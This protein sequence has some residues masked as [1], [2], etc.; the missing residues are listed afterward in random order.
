MPKRKRSRI[1]FIIAIFSAATCAA[2]H[3]SIAETITLKTGVVL[4]G[5]LGKDNTT[6]MVDDGLRHIL[7][8]D[9]K[10]ARVE[11]DSGLGGF[12]SFQLI[13]PQKVHA[14][15]MPEAVL[16]VEATDWD[17]NGRRTFSYI[18]ARGG[19]TTRRLTMT[20]ALT[21]L[22]PSR[23]RY[24]GVDG[25]WKDGQ[26]S[27]TQV[28]RTVVLALLSR[29][30]RQD[31]SQR[32]KVCRFLIEAGWY[33]EA[34]A[35][36]DRLL[37]DF[38]DPDVRDRA[39]R[40][41]D[42]VR[43]LRA[44]SL[45]I[46]V[47]NRLQARRPHAALEI[48]KTFPSEGL[49]PELLDRAKTL[50]R[51]RQ[52]EADEDKRLADALSQT[53]E[54]L[55][56]ALR[57]QTAGALLEM[58]QGLTEAPDA[59]RS[60]LDAFDKADPTRT[61]SERFA[62]ALSGWIV[63]ERNAVPEIDRALLLWKARGL[64]RRY[65]QT[66]DGETEERQAILASLR[67]SMTGEVGGKGK[68]MLDMDAIERLAAHLPPPLSDGRE[69]PGEVRIARVID[70]RNAEPTEYAVFLPP[71]YSPLRSYPTVVALHSGQEETSRARMESAI[72]WWS[73][74]AA[75]RGY[76]VI[77]PEYAVSGRVPEYTYTPNEHAA[78][79]LA[80]RD[81]GKRF[82]VD[83][84]RVFLG[85][86]LRGGDMAW[87]LGLAHPDLFAGVAV[88]SGRP[89]KYVNANMS[90]LTRLPFYLVFG[91]LAGGTDVI[92]DTRVKPLIMRNYDLMF[93]EYINRGLEAFPEEAPAIFDWAAPRVRRAVP[94]AF[95]VS[96]AR[97]CDDRFYGV[98][99]GQFLPGRAMPPEAVQA[100]GGNLR[101]A[102]IEQKFSKTLNRL[103][104]STDGLRSYDVW[105]SPRLLDFKKKIVVVAN[106]RIVFRA[107]PKP[108][109]E[110]YL[111]DLRL[112]ADRGQVYRLKVPVAF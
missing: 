79:V 108:D 36:I 48:L 81:A 80:L 6:W 83:S 19:Q 32:E 51:E 58:L 64:I 10:V 40:A 22:E 93:V 98:V 9:S 29:V 63:G 73:T 76:I 94:A 14:G 28:P 39:R 37:R 75:K 34:I 91:E 33:D 90:H 111:E 71:E 59:V 13:Q 109:P 24:R 52:A 99:V 56:T 5:H 2:T 26:I 11:P 21:E 61:A 41:R 105:L 104:L 92:R 77:A 84:D 44:E 66:R 7:F 86:A 95:R 85:G 27:L 110:P 69:R 62:L 102:H 49:T 47:Q 101:P 57:K 15:V 68:P 50:L 18:G 42:S 4:K 16:S 43:I 107:L 67:E 72:A 106:G 17:K 35:E 87:D 3:R 70:D 46:D 30:D 100:D 112:R 55:P 20:Q 53:A 38:T 54:S 60:R 96:T 74:E 45:L 25:F 89:F 1:A 65:L 31:L 12:D 23:A 82:A 8:R 97:E 78:V 103:S 88:V